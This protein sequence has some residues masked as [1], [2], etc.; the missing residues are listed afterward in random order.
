MDKIDLKVGIYPWIPDL[1]KDGLKGLKEFVK[2]EFEAEHPHISL[3]V[4][5]DWD[6]YNV[7][8]VANKY[9]SPS[10]SPSGSSFDVLEI[11]TILL[12][13][14]ADHGTLQH[15]NLEKYISPGKFF[16]AGLDA[17]T[18][19]GHCCAVPT[20]HCANFLIEL[21]SGD[22]EVQ[23]EILCSLET[24][25]HNLGDLKEVVKKYHKLFSGV[26]PLVGDFRGK[27]TLPC[28]YLDAFIDKHGA[29]SV[30][31]GVDAPI[32]EPD[33]LD[34]MK[35]FMKLDEGTD[36]TN[37]G[38]SDEYDGATERDTDIAKSDH[39]MMYGYS[40]WLSQVMSDK[41]CKKKKIHAS[42]VISPPLGTENHLL[43]FTDAL[44]VSKSSYS[45]DDKRARAID[46]FI[47]FY[48]SLSFRNKYAAGAD[49]KEPHPPRY[50]M[51]ARKDFYT[52][53]F[54]ATQ[55]NYQ[56]LRDAMDYSVAAPNHGLAGRHEEM[57]R[58]LGEKLGLPK[59]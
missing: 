39:I 6:P 46:E 33:V 18:Y 16:G 40:E 12:G 5:T 48:T 13:E 49:L 25:N 21:I 8:D 59:V 26:S 9:L 30:Q 24:G 2:H 19:N 29:D 47:S 55:K 35:W 32:D 11:D 27:W 15:L 43:T 58:I 54:G 51:I 23:E 42:C 56:K 4:S 22:A 57:N 31:E 20:L 36:G 53:G 41:M 10:S 52:D 1:D 3:T 7:N 44:I 28:F 17:V 38:T 45:S 34:N 14:V 37:K 50:V